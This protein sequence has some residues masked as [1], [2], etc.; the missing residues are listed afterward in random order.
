MSSARNHPACRLPLVHSGRLPAPE[1]GIRFNYESTNLTYHRSVMD[2]VAADEVDRV[3]VTLRKV[4]QIDA[5]A[6]KNVRLRKCLCAV[7]SSE[8]FKR[9]GRV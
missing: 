4:C 2:K 6:H 1:Q 3:L 8:C 7:N 9:A 5:L